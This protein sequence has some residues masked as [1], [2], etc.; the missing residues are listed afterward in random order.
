MAD[1]SAVYYIAEGVREEERRGKP[2]AAYNRLVFGKQL[3]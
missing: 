1:A 3:D 2:A